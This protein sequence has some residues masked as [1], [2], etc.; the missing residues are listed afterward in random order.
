ME[1]SLLAQGDEE[2]AAS[3]TLLV[4]ASLFSQAAMARAYLPAATW[5]ILMLCK[6]ISWIGPVPQ[7]VSLT[8]CLYRFRWDQSPVGDGR[9]LSAQLLCA[10]P[11][12]AHAKCCVMRACLSAATL[13]S[14]SS[15]PPSVYS[16]L[17]VLMLDQETLLISL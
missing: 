11:T 8:L 2:G 1:T 16:F 4:G 9:T 15:L 3:P 17:K 10:I 13:S 12:V 6:Y 7:S 5:E 14:S